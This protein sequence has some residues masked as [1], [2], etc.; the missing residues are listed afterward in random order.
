MYRN[1]CNA[2]IP[3]VPVYFLGANSRLKLFLDR[4]LAF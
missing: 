1:P 2:L 3:A 4:G